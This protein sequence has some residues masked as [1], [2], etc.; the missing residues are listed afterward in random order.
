MLRIEF[1]EVANATT[2][3]MEGRF[4]GR[5]AEDAQELVARCKIPSN[6][7]VNLSEV[8]FVDTSGEEVLSW[9]SQVGVKFVAES[10]YALDVCDRLKLPLLPQ[11]SRSLPEVF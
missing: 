11:C 2:I 1:Q 10:A 7:V 5:F 6:V 8:S 9:L 3:R 4:V